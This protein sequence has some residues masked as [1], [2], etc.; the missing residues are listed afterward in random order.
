MG[1]FN[2]TLQSS[3][4][5][6]LQ[7]LVS[8][9]DI[10]IYTLQSAE[11]VIVGK[12]YACVHSGR[13]DL[14]NKLLHLLHS[15]ISA[16][17]NK[18]QGDRASESSARTSPYTLNP[19][20]T[21]TL[22]DGLSISSNRPILQHWLDFILMTI[23]Q[24]HD[25]LQPTIIPLNDRI[26]R[27][28]RDA[29]TEVKQA[30]SGG[31][32][33]ADVAIYTTDADFIML[34]NAMERLVLLSL[35]HTPDAGQVEDDMQ[36][37]KTTA[38]GGGLLGYVSNVFSTDSGAVVAEEQPLVSGLVSAIIS[39]T[40][41][42]VQMK[43]FDGHCL[44]EAIRVAYAIWEQLVVP[45]QPSWGSLEESLALI[46]TRARARCRRVLEHLFKAHPLEVLESLVE[47]WY[48]N[49][50]VRL[51]YALG[52]DVLTD[53]HSA[54]THCHSSWWT[55][56][57]PMRK[58]LFTCCARRSLYEY[59]ACP[60]DLSDTPCVRLR[61]YRS[62]MLARTSCSILPLRLSV[63]PMSCCSNSSSNI[64]SA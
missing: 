16:L 2:E 6:L 56:S 31:S 57:L 18:T 47:C 11:S 58:R 35:S 62:A 9:G 5:D 41:R 17:S 44:Q 60:N 8:R 33:A 23:P 51:C 39:G 30:S 34:L 43:S 1:P 4:V 25:M 22:I 49:E 59:P 28:L 13:L 50:T 14:Q 48:R 24:F 53:L 27:Q 52:G 63:A 3:V 61:E 12:L 7:A 42:S 55:S 20:L 64:L 19:L 26:C 54:T 32:R 15:F 37:E 46:Y 29:L 40:N 45:T 36:P 38:E 21:Q 10:D